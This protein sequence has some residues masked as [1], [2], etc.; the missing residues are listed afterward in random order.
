[1]FPL[2]TPRVRLDIAGGDRCLLTPL[3]LEREKLAKIIDDYNIIGRCWLAT[4][5]ISV[6]TRTAKK[7]PQDSDGT[8]A[9]SMILLV[10]RRACATRRRLEVSQSIVV[11]LVA[12]C[13]TGPKRVNYLLLSVHVPFFLLE[14]E[15]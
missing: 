14:G 15:G 3:R 8:G 12:V 5:K 10:L 2:R 11:V 9:G 6:R 1:M 4:I 13:Y 7:R